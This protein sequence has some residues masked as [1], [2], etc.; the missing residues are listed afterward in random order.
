[1]GDGGDQ[2]DTAGFQFSYNLGAHQISAG[3]WAFKD[4][5]LTL[6][7]AT[8]VP[9]RASAGPTADGQVYSEVQFGEINRG[10]IDL[11]TTLRDFSARKLTIGV[12]GQVTTRFACDAKNV[13]VHRRLGI[14]RVY[15][16]RR[17]R[18]RDLYLRLSDF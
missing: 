8:G 17:A 11:S 3:D 14:P 7:L 16:Q 6:R 12:D 1:M 2:G 13:L 10:D 15:Q 18:R 9:N 5:R 4:L